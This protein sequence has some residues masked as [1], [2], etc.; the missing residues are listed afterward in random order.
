MGLTRA[1]LRFYAA[2]NAM[3]VLGVAVAVAVLAGALLVGSS[4]RD[5]LRELALSRLGA[6]DIVVT[7]PTFFRA[8]LADDVMARRSFPLRSAAPM[9]VFDGAVVHDE[10]KRT[11]GRVAVYGIDER[12]G[13]FHGIDSLGVTG[14]E[15]LLSPAL[16]AEL[17]ARAGDTV[18]VRVARPS[19]IP[20]ASLQGR[21]ET[22]GERIRLN[23]TRVLDQSAL[24]EFSLAPSQG[25]VL[26]IYVPMARLQRDLD[27]GERVNV[28]LIGVNDP[29]QDVAKLVR[30]AIA[31][32]ASLDDLGLRARETPDGQTSIESR[33]GFL[34]NELAAEVKRI[35]AR[36]GRTVTPALTYVANTIRIG[37][38]QIPYSTVTAIDAGGLT[39][40]SS[41]EKG[42]D[43]HA[44][45]WLNEWAATDLDAKLGDEITL[46]YF[47][48]N[49]DDGLETRQATFSF[50]GVVSMTGIGGDRTLTPDYP[51][52]SDAAD[53][54]SWDPPFPVELKRIRPKDEDYWDEWPISASTSSI[55]VSSSWSPRC[56]WPTCS[57]RSDSNSARAK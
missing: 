34:T 26:A 29:V 51:G 11:A 7:S 32:V 37:N 33:A 22:T 30:D 2:T 5:S 18:T 31:P 41:V 9:I 40:R 54:T 52:I 3:V 13:R 10:S 21:R 16:A 46:E 39:P 27:L 38:R 28:L 4:V 57:S 35:A 20:L 23:V 36:D 49:D 6:T 25:P 14:R 50:Q 1:S 19:D 15:A 48:W 44:A 24:G 43:P 8:A 42:S 45:I 53:M 17:G 55:S 47:I 12:F 56:Y